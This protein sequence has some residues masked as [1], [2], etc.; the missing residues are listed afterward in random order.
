MDNKTER[1]ELNSY[2]ENKGHGNG[3]LKAEKHKDVAAKDNKQINA[4]E[5]E[6]ELGEF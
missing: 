6:D 4:P 1:A 2:F 5:F 3:E